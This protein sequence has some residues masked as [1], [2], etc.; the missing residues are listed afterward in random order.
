MKIEER[1]IVMVV[2]HESVPYS[3][4]GQVGVVS[5]ASPERLMVRFFGNTSV[6][7]GLG[8]G[9]SPNEVVKI[10][11]LDDDSKFLTMEWRTH[12][13]KCGE[14]FGPSKVA[15]RFVTQTVDTGEWVEIVTHAL[16][17]P[18]CGLTQT[19]KTTQRGV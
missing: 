3:F 14:E 8:H 15:E 19:K 6:A 11:R 9:A 4:L 1:D 10:G 18:E 13:P 16:V 5:S 2:G 17:C 12:C 7:G